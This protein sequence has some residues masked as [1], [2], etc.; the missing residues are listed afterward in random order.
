MLKFAIFATSISDRL[1][2]FVVNQND[3]FHGVKS[4]I[5]NPGIINVH[6]ENNVNIQIS[7]V[8]H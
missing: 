3:L 6:R 8:L 7:R 5:L 1:G 2:N 4:S